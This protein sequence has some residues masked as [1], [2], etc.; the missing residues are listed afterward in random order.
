VLTADLVTARRRGDELR[1]IPVDDERRARIATLAA[2]FS[3]VARAHIG[4]TRRELDDAFE[5]RA[6]DADV[7]GGDRRLIGAVQKLVQDGCTFEEPDAE[8]AA[9]LRRE[10]F[11]RAAAA[12]RKAT[13]TAPFDRDALLEAA[14]R[15][16]GTTPEAIDAGLYA[17]RPARQRLLAFAA[18]P[19]ATLAAGFALAEAQAVLL[20][21]TR[22]TANVR[23]RDAGTYRHLF[24]TLKFL[25]LLPVV[26]ATKDGGYIITLD[27]PLSLFQSGTRYGLQ[28]GL[29]LPVI[30]ACDRW[31][32]EADVRWG[33]DRRP[34]HFRA[35]G[36]A[37]LSDAAVPALPDE[38]SAFV[39]A[40][41]RLDSGWL[42]EREPAVLDL[43]G[44]GVCVPDLA[45][46]RAADGA[47]VHFELLGF[48]SR[49][50]VWRR[51]ELVRAG[52]PHRILF[53]VSKALRVGEAVLDDTPTAALYVFTRVIGAKQV[54]DR[55]EQLAAS[56]APDGP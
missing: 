39:A 22:V 4:S 54:L 35:A 29:A 24:R 43:P 13:P 18:R 40:F 11:R 12:R 5:A 6:S 41:E 49:E 27:G 55:L 52:L 33:V 45:F 28:L 53:A 23:A 32:I 20:R 44:A 10:I 37:V 56:E 2:A 1:L 36:A 34:L 17:D 19:P 16:R 47:R 3:D 48:W 25:R 31:S 51:V 50:A 21:A 42:I 30:A 26:T 15:E 8:T 38:L 46:V 9:T 7:P 14:A